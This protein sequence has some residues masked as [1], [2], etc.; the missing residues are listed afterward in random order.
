MTRQTKTTEHRVTETSTRA[1]RPTSTH[2][3]RTTMADT[4]TTRHSIKLTTTEPERS[5][6]SQVTGRLLFSCDFEK[7]DDLCGMKQS[8]GIQPYDHAS[9]TS[10]SIV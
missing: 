5:T 6:S 3:P 8:T 10:P 7:D 2:A 4:T 9:L 1:T